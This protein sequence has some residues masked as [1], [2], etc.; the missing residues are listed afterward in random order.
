MKRGVN[1]QIVF[2]IA[3][4]LLLLMAVLLPVDIIV[5]RA[6]SPAMRREI[7]E[8]TGPERLQQLQT[9]FAE[10]LTYLRI[11]AAVLGVWLLG[12]G[13][14]WRKLLAIR[15]HRREALDIDAG[16]RRGIS[17]LLPV[18]PWFLLTLLLAL[19]LMF[20]G[21]E[22]QEVLTVEMLA[23]RGPLV[24]VAMQNVPPRAAQP[25][26][27][28]I[29]SMLVLA[30]GEAEWVARLPALL[31]GAAVL[32]PLFFVAHRIV[33][34]M[35]AHLACVLLL[36]TPL[37][38]FR[39]TYGRG[40]SLGM[41][42]LWMAILMA[43]RA[44]EQNR[45]REWVA[46][47][48]FMF[49]ACYSHLSLGISVAFLCVATIAN[50]IRLSL[51]RLS[52]QTARD[53]YRLQHVAADFV[54]AFVVFGTTALALVTVYSIGI[55]VEIRYLQTFGTSEYYTAYQPDMRLF[56]VM[57][58]LWTYIRGWPA[59]AW[60]HFGLFAIGILALLGVHRWKTACFM[61]AC[62][63]PVL[64]LIALD[65][66]IYPRFFLFYLP[67]YVLGVAFALYGAV[68]T[69]AR[70]FSARPRRTINLA[71]GL[72]MAAVILLAIPGFRRLYAMERCGVRSAVNDAVAVMDENDRLAGVLDGFIT[73]RHYYP[74][75]VSMERDTDF[76]A[77]LH[78]DSPP[79]F[80]INVPYLEMDIPG[81][82]E[83]LHQQYKLY[84]AYP[85]WMDVDSDSDSIYLYRRKTED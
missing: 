84:K 16:G 30:W 66:F 44:V 64:V 58:E 1:S 21:Y 2:L 36:F 27:T 83:A 11:S 28:A 63:G 57:I 37:L 18:L 10:G 14:G 78:S 22:H 43:M 15:V 31:F 68:M 81:G 60:T 24:S 71:T 49:F 65:H 26:Y 40:Y 34:A 32:F 6:I 47:G 53:G 70:R 45:W 25:A 8:N 79:E 72:L 29:K 51:I 75:A 55:P 35:F 19:P 77:E 38:H 42:A 76:W 48:V 69:V 67:G 33:G 39:I 17:K 62:L 5:A 23:R 3:A 13:A 59:L 56:R 50:N 54:P 73:V 85:S 74:D 41:F 61:A 7:I 12:L 80:I 82:T 4:L 20:K 46:A 9:Q 52:L